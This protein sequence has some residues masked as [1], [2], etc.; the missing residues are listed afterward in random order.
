MTRWLLVVPLAVAL[1][2]LVLVLTVG[3]LLGAALMIGA[4]M[5]LV[6]VTVP[7]VVERLVLWLGTG[8]VRRRRF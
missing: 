3:S 8:S 2:G 4:M 6:V 7:A 5:A 1:A